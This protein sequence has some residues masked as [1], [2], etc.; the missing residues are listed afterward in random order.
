MLLLL[1]CFAVAISHAAILRSASGS[2]RKVGP[3]A[4]EGSQRSDGGALKVPQAT[5]QGFLPV[6]PEKDSEMF[7]MYY[8]AREETEDLSKTPIVLWLQ[9]SMPLEPRARR[10]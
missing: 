1:Q 4:A 5:H 10:D 6:N 7:F 9:V 3:V 8:E 2:I